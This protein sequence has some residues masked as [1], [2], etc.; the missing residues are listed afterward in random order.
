MLIEND[1]Q[2]V[3]NS[4]TCMKTNANLGVI[5]TYACKYIPS[6]FLCKRGM[7]GYLNAKKSQNYSN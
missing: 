5:S 3:Y 4:T 2:Y 1:N 6:L 7:L